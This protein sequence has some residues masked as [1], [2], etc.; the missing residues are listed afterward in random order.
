MLKF[1][2]GFET[3]HTVL[4]TNITAQLI[5][6][7]T[8]NVTNSDGI[9]LKAGR[10][11][12]LAIMLD[13][14][15]SDVAAALMGPNIGVESDCVAGIGIKTPAT[16]TLVRPLFSFMDN[17]TEQVGL[18]LNA[19][20]FLEFRNGSGTILQTSSLPIAA[21]TWYYF[22][23]KF[24]IHN[25]TGSYQVKQDG[26]TVLAG[27]AVDT[28]NTV[29]A[30]F[31]RIRIGGYGKGARALLVDDIYV[32]DA[33]GSVNN[34]FLGN[35]RTRLMVA[36][37]AGDNAEW[38][39]NTGTNFEA[40]EEIPSDSD[41]TYIATASVGALDL[42]NQTSLAHGGTSIVGVLSR[43][44]ARKEEDDAGVALVHKPGGGTAQVGATLA[45]TSTSYVVQ[46]VLLGL[47]P[48]TG[49]AWNQTQINGLQ[50]GVKKIS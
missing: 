45:I 17:A 46:S 50:I 41:T 4:D 8:G 12:G 13:G 6:V 15:G 30:T 34:T 35:F 3:Y 31:D 43:L 36:D 14:T 5:K 9:L 20:G 27:S 28:Q 7:W 37:A 32:N 47:N 1:M 23:C 21:A 39:P 44:I 11:G 38:T 16:F 42:H 25:S 24:V 19:T 33:S 40:V 49:L 18:Y 48:E 10:T 26:V 2:E 29:N 22:E